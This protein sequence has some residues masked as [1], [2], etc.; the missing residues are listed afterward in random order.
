MTFRTLSQH[1]DP[2]YPVEDL[3]EHPANPRQGDDEAV[4]E[5]VEASGFYGAIL[6]QRSTGHVLAGNTRLRVAR[7][8]G[9]ATVPVFVVDVDDTT[10]TRILLGDNRLSD[11]ATYNE[12]ALL[13]ALQALEGDLVGTGYTEDDLAD[14][15]AGLAKAT[16]GD[17]LDGKKAA[18]GS[19]S[20]RFLVAPV[21]VLNAR[22][23]EWMERKRLWRSRGLQDAEGRMGGLTYIGANRFADHYEHKRRVEAVL[24][25]DI[26]TSEAE[27]YLE[28]MAT[29]DLAKTG[30]SAFDPVLAE[31]LLSWYSPPGGRVLDPFAGGPTR[32]LMSSWLGRHY[33][34]VDLRPEQVAH[35]ATQA[36]TLL[37]APTQAAPAESQPGDLSPVQRYGNRWLKR[38]DLFVLAGSAGGKVRS[39]WHLASQPGVRGLVTA[40]SRHS[41]QANIVAGI[42][43]RLG[44]PCRIHTATGPATPEMEAAAAAGAEIIRHKPGYNTVL[45]ARARADAAA[46]EA[47]GWVHI[48]F[49]ME[50]QAAVEQ[51]AA[52]VVNLPD[53]AARLVVPVGSGMSLAGILHGLAQ[54]G[55]QVPVLGVVV[56]ADPTSRLDAY[57]PAD[58]R[59]R[60]TLVDASVPYEDAV[61][62]VV[63]GVRLDP[64]YEAKCAEHLRDGD[65]LWV[66]GCRQTARDLP[67]PTGP[68]PTWVTGDSSQPATWDQVD[69]LGGDL[70]DMVLTCPPYADLEVY[71]DDPADLSNMDVDGWDQGQAAALA[72][73]CARLRPGG[74]AAVVMGEARGGDSNGLYGLVGRTQAHLV[75]AGCDVWAHYI[76]LTP[77]GGARLVVARQFAANRSPARVHQH[78]LVARRQGGPTRVADQWGLLSGV[79]DALATLQADQEDVEDTLDN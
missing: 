69:A 16:V 62:A 61:D 76:M 70:Y 40:G 45:V 24:G 12:D 63:A 31:V 46:L 22:S 21:S 42:A 37:A 58:W 59:K 51:T 74:F 78:V 50:H 20:E 6:V 17:S 5:S 9:A 4:A 65:V 47:E 3:T 36:A 33:V 10:A 18:A 56:G 32:G 39:C 14:L 34:G 60:C 30:T 71:S 64:H 52:Q 66:V 19:L 73:A 49:G 1:Y 77:I 23:G 43:K 55:S 67:V 68:V 75:A 25:R 54:I 57:A 44:I 11:L 7:A 15:V 2:A 48:P 29:N 41:P 8:A 79:E 72:H 28:R 26:T 13:A 53:E 35:N 27:G 38:E